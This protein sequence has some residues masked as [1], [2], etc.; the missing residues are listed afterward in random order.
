MTGELCRAVKCLN[1]RWYLKW[2]G[3]QAPIFLFCCS[4]MLEMWIFTGLEIRS[5]FACQ[6]CFASSIFCSAAHGCFFIKNTSSQMNLNQSIFLFL[7][8]IPSLS[9]TAY[10]LQPI[11][12]DIGQ[13]AGYTLDTLPVYQRGWNIE[14]NNQSHSLLEWSTTLSALTVGGSWS[15]WRKPAN[16]TGQWGP[17]GQWAL[18]QSGLKPRTFLL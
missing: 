2:L 3:S 1:S 11:L 9:V 18:P 16:S 5:C 8:F 12:A 7:T 13:I 4:W 15:T 14:T 17:A 10:P 6:R